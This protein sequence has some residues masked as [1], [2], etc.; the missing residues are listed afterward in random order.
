M[1]IRYAPPAPMHTSPAEDPNSFVYGDLSHV[2]WVVSAPEF[3]P[4]TR[5]FAGDSTDG[6]RSR[7]LVGTDGYCPPG[8]YL[9][10]PVTIPAGV[11]TVRIE[12]DAVELPAGAV[13][14]PFT[15]QLLDAQGVNVLGSLT[16]TPTGTATNVAT[17]DIA[18]TAGV[19]YR[20]R[21]VCRV[22]A[23]AA[24]FLAGRLRLRPTTSSDL[25]WR[26]SFVRLEAHGAIQ[27]S[28]EIIWRNPRFPAQ[29]ASSFLELVTDAA[30]VRVE[31]SP[32]NL[33]YIGASHAHIVPT[34]DDYPIAP[35]V[36]TADGDVEYLAASIPAAGGERTVRIPAGMTTASSYASPVIEQQGSF[37]AALYVPAS[38]SARLKTAPV[39]VL[40]EVGDS[41]EV[42]SYS[43]EPSRDALGG[44]LRAA[45]WRVINAAT[46]GGSLYAD[47]G[48]TVSQAACAPLA[49]RLVRRGATRVHV[50][51]GR[52]D[53]TGS[54][55]SSANLVSQIGY[56]LDALH[57]ALPAA[58][59]VIETWTSEGAENAIGGTAWD[60]VRELIRALASSRSTWCVVLDAAR[61]WTPAEQATFTSDTVHPNSLGYERKA[62]GLL[63]FQHPWSPLQLTPTIWC[64]TTLRDTLTGGAWGS[65][66]AAGTS[67][68]TVS[69]AGSP[70]VCSRLLLRVTLGGARGT[71]LFD[72]SL[73]GGRSWPWRGIATA[74]SADLKAG[75][76]TLATIAFASGT[77]YNDNV[78]Y[79][80]AACAQ[81]GDASGNGNHLATTS[82]YRPAYVPSSANLRPG[83]SFVGASS[84]RLSI[85]GLSIAAPY[86]VAVIGSM[87]SQATVQP[88]IGRASAGTA[89][90][91]YANTST[92]V[93]INAG[94]AQISATIDATALHTYVAVVNGSV[95][96]GSSL[97]VDGA[98][99]TGTLGANTLSSLHLGYDTNPWALTGKI[100]GFVLVPRVMS[101]SE[102][103]CLEAR[104][105]ALFGAP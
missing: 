5:P 101:T 17:T 104:W 55:Y 10:R 35:L 2:A 68:P 9:E 34:V 64:E 53:W 23:T 100:L 58:M 20:V 36:P 62:R 31:T 25:F 93:A 84:Q 98:V 45:G 80:D 87:T 13:A 21:V 72:A 33:R 37:I 70:S 27:D 29:S 1:E 90:L 49:M 51:I 56:L 19:E 66:T 91:L 26:S 79:A 88:F 16:V 28:A 12:L 14:A 44:L 74:A 86:T 85:S 48:S 24:K 39:E 61:Y 97:R 32:T 11:S 4:A 8:G 83:L 95:V 52:N 69:F 67:P 43:D 75:D 76:T 105:R 77:Y 71:A 46:G 65:V 73:D 78:Y 59:I 22:G 89:P 94:A 82:S 54:T 18:V 60:T 41:K 15:L 63:G 96:N 81:L 47:V 7:V 102:C 6:R 40:I 103:L 50:E 99:T 42:G 92:T 38:A 3:A 30:E 57:A